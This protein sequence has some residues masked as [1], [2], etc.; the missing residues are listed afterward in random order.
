ML[1]RADALIEGVGQALCSR[2]LLHL[3]G[4]FWRAD[5]GTAMPLDEP[6]YG[7]VSSGAA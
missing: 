6:N 1:A 2:P 5:E 7:W 4:Y 3:L